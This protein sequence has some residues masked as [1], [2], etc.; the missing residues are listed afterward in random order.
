MSEIVE[1]PNE[2]VE[3]AEQVQTAPEPP[4]YLPQTDIKENENGFLLVADLPGADPKSLEVSFEEAI[5]TI[6]AS[7]APQKREGFHLTYG[8]YEPGN[9]RR[10]FRLSEE[11]D[12]SRI[13]A[14]LKDGVLRI[15]LPRTLKVTR[16]I[17]VQVDA[18]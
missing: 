11:I 13:S 3:Q 6:R 5:L 8:E 7:A 14:N 17:P 12:A 2:E 16:R 1:R 15:D 9:Y 10:S 18:G 4:T